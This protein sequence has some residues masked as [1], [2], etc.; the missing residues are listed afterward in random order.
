MTRDR[1]DYVLT[2]ISYLKD[3]VDLDVQP[4]YDIID[5][6]DPQDIQTQFPLLYKIDH[7]AEHLY[8]YS[9]DESYRQHA[10]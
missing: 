7:E 2:S 9:I 6:D 10:D 4:Q 8:I 3:V 5:E 1:Q